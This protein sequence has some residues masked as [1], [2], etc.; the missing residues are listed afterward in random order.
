MPWWYHA[1]QRQWA[2]QDHAGA[3]PCAAAVCR[4][5]QPQAAGAS[6]FCAGGEHLAHQLAWA[7]QRGETSRACA[8]CRTTTPR[9]RR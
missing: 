8:I 5:Q 7:V 9:W 3:P 2:L 4:C 6:I 1:R